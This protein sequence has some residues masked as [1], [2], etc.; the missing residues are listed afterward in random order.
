M[1]VSGTHP[2][3]GRWITKQGKI[4]DKFTCE[5]VDAPRSYADC[6]LA[7]SVFWENFVPNFVPTSNPDELP[8][9]A[10]PV[11]LTACKAGIYRNSSHFITTPV[12][13]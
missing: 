8:R 4:Q 13:Y 1:L 5:P 10:M 3:R 6:A 11:D 7:V 12:T 9:I 2:I